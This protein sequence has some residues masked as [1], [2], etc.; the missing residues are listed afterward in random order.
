MPGRAG[1]AIGAEEV[2]RRLATVIL[3]EEVRED[4]KNGVKIDRSRGLEVK[5]P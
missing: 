5:W 4:E 1:E 2:M 3:G